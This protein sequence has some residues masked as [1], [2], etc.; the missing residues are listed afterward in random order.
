M[1]TNREI[2]LNLINKFISDFDDENK[3]AFWINYKD[4]AIEGETFKKGSD[5]TKQLDGY[6][7]MG[8][9]SAFTVVGKYEEI[10]FTDETNYITK[11]G[12]YISFGKL[13][14]HE[15]KNVVTVFDSELG[16]SKKELKNLY[17]RIVLFEMGINSIDSFLDNF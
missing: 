13:L 3:E 5:H 4:S 16:F 6:F 15:V 14:Q 17:D 1:V 11:E 12:H 8:D 10:Y 2:A 7:I 9:N